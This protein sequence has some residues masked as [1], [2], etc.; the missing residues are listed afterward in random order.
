MHVTW[1]HGAGVPKCHYKSL[2]RHYRA[3]D[4]FFFFLP[5]FWENRV[6]KDGQNVAFF[7]RKGHLPILSPRDKSPKQM[8]W[9]LNK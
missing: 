6:S 3:L 5:Q 2:K 9:M 8:L 7:A 4:F 1:V